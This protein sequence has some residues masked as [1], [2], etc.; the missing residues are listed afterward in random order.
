MR[1][2]AQA[3]ARYR[4]SG[5]ADDDD[6]HHHLASRTPLSMGT[7]CAG[8][9][10]W[11]GG[12]ADDGFASWEERWTAG[13]DYRRSSPERVARFVEDEFSGAEPSESSLISPLAG[14]VC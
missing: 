4:R 12:D 10:N 8:A 9:P 3:L 7:T 11:G 1:P 14:S 6:G 13:R 5:V 2:D